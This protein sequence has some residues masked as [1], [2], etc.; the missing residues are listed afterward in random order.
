MKDDFSDVW[1]LLILIVLLFIV[2]TMGCEIHKPQTRVACNNQVSTTNPSWQVEKEEW[3][4]CD[5][6]R[7]VLMEVMVE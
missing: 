2:P 5:D 4:R 7:M 3:V 6:G 1:L